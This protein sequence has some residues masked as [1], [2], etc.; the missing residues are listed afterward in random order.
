[1]FLLH[2][3]TQRTICRILFFVCCVVPLLATVVW[4]A[5][6]HRPWQLSDW[7]HRLTENLHLRVAVENVARPRPG[8]TTLGNV[9]L[10]DLRSNGLLGRLSDLRCQWE[11]GRLRIQA[12]LLEVEARHLMQASAAL[13][14][15]LSVGEHVSVDLQVNQLVFIGRHSSGAAWK[16]LQMSSRAEGPQGRTVELWAEASE[17]KRPVHL[18]VRAQPSP[19]GPVIH[20][21]FDTQQSALPVWL[22]DDLIPG[23]MYRS[24]AA[25]FTGT[26]QVEC[27]A[28]HVRGTLQGNFAP[29]DLA[30]WLGPTT[31][32]RAAGSATVQ[33]KRLVWQ[34]DR[35]LIARG[36]LRAVGGG[37]NGPLL[38]AAST[39]FHC[40]IPAAVQRELDRDPAAVLPFDEMALG[41]Q[42]DDTGIHITGQA[43]AGPILA[44][45]KSAGVREV[46]CLLAHQGQQLLLEPPRP[47]PVA[48]LVQLLHLPVAGWLPDTEEAHEM[49]G[50][51]PLPSA[52]R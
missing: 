40:E 17:E 25:R 3:T 29:I 5:Y 44:G 35:V 21:I 49:A 33:L 2:E 14:T 12:D 46:G 20:A 8:V 16:N 19:V 38:S 39:L 1:M 28:Q 18:V 45:N 10:A 31:P 22:M 15:W 23:G 6:C 34:D 51:L 30:K 42:L 37:L 52:T 32:H 43:M 26:A 48:R 9:R 41:F 24:P 36:E 7:Q 13:A 4:I 11:S 47:L 27:G 50:R